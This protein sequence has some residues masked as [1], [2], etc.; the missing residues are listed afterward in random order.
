MKIN[1]NIVDLDELDER[2]KKEIIKKKPKLVVDK[3]IK[4]DKKEEGDV[5]F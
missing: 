5:L 3:P 2:P 4:K 1:I